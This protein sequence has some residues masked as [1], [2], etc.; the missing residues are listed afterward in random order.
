MIVKRDGAVDSDAKK[1]DFSDVVWL[2]LLTKGKKGCVIN[3]LPNSSLF[4]EFF[5]PDKIATT[6]IVNNNYYC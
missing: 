6:I 3:V 4:S 5:K 2:R 1:L